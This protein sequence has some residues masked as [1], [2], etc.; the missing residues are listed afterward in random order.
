MAGRKLMIGHIKYT[1]GA[2]IP[3]R[4]AMSRAAESVGIEWHE[5]LALAEKVCDATARAAT[6]KAIEEMAGWSGEAWQAAKERFA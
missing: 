1:L 3:Q 2:T 6:D 5:M 4:D